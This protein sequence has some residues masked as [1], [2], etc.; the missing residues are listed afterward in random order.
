MTRGAAIKEWFDSLIPGVTAY[1]ETAVPSKADGDEADAQFPYLTYSGGN[2]TFGE[3]V[4]YTV[5][6][7]F[8]T[9]DEAPINAAETVLYQKLNTGGELI[10]SDDGA[11]WM[12][13][14]IPF[15]Q[16]VTDEDNR[17]KRRYI[18]IT[19]ERISA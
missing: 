4:A 8:Y 11:F 7:W 16:P 2:V 6:L 10:F 1:P 5:N 9:E 17:V 19:M 15:S 12:K 13:A 3:E 14:G 18:N